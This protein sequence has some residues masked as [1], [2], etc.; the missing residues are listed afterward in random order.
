MDNRQKAVLNDFREAIKGNPGAN[1]QQCMQG[2]LGAMQSL[3]DLR[4]AIEFECGGCCKTVSAELGDVDFFDFFDG[5]LLIFGDLKLKE[6]CDK[7]SKK[8]IFLIIIP[9]D[10]ISSFEV[11]ERSCYCPIAEA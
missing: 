4:F 8:D 7:V 10:K 2:V 3:G 11:F 9:L 6:C 1:M 5:V